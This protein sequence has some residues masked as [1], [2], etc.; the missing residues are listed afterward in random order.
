VVGCVWRMI[1]LA[2]APVPCGTLSSRQ[3]PMSR[4]ALDQISDLVPR[5]RLSLAAA[6]VVT[7]RLWYR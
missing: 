2:A 7:R 5:W 1:K 6:H 3:G 4:N